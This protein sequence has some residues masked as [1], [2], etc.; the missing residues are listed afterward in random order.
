MKRHLRLLYFSL[1]F[2]SFSSLFAQTRKE[3]PGKGTLHFRDEGINMGQIKEEDGPAMAVF[4]CFNIG[5]SPVVI[6]NVKTSCGCTVSDWSRD[7]LA[8]GDSGYVIAT[9]DPRSRPGPFEKGLFVYNDGVPFE[10]FLTIAGEVIPRPKTVE[11]DYPS[12]FGKLMM[13]SNY[14][15][16]G[17]VYK[18]QV[19]T[20]KAKIYNASTDTIRI[21]GVSGRPPH[22]LMKTSSNILLPKSQNEITFIYDARNSGD[23]AW[24]DQLHYLKLLT[25][26]INVPE[27]QMHIQAHVWEQF[28]KQTK[29]RVKKNPKVSFDKEQFNYGKALVG[30]TVEVRYTIYNTGKKPL[31]IRRIYGSC[32]CTVTTSDKE[33]IAGGDSATLIVKFNTSG[34]SGVEDKTIT[35]ITNDPTRPVA[36]LSFTGEV[37]QNPNAL[38]N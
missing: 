28:P 38:K 14:F 15:N 30:D 16:F 37:V 6:T 13:T 21:L 27:L 32:G 12:K 4:R 2:I 7:T 33:S 19:D 29:R 22:V 17:F 34:R 5:K 25:D 9:Y 10:I 31:E 8:P 24:G 35:V 18:N 3:W 26:D 23:E 20:V 1:V 11:D 36:K